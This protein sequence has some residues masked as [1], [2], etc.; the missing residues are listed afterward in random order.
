MLQT[1]GL[2]ETTQSVYRFVLN[3]QGCGI[4]EVADTLGLPKDDVLGHVARLADLRLVRR[5]DGALHSGSPAVALQSLL[6]RQQADLLRQQQEFA[7]A[8]AAASRL[9]AEY[10]Q[11]YGVGTRTEW[12][13]LDDA[14]AIET[15]MAALARQ[16][17]TEWLFMVPPGTQPAEHLTAR[18]PLDEDLLRRGVPVSAIFQDCVRND[19]ATMRYATWLAQAGGQVTTVPTLPIWLVIVD[20]TAA[21]VPA[22]PKPGC[23][24]AF[25]VTGPGIVAAL[26]ALFERIWATGACVGSCRPAFDDEPSPLELELLRLLGEGLTDEAVCKKLGIGLR[27]ARRMVAD[28]MSKLGARSRFEAGANAVQRGWLDPG[29]GCS[30]WR[31]PRQRQASPDTAKQGDQYADAS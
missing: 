12:E 19:R 28:L 11:V 23:L 21:L 26:T 9:I 14:R 31:P 10:E 4:A 17:R 5:Q 30:T 25:E 3:H 2:D 24:S 20:R 7:E 22:D 13:R 18:K 1:L 16:A 8:R 15:R 29:R 27:T 6:Q